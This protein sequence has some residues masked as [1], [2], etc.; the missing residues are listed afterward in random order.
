MTLDEPEDILFTELHEPEGLER[1]GDQEATAA[2][3]T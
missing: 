2:S 3:T 1:T